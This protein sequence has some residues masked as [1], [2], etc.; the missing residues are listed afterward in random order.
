VVRFL[1]VLRYP[2]FLAACLPLAWT[3]YRE[4]QSGQEA[5][6]TAGSTGTPPALDEIEARLKPLHDRIAWT[7]QPGGAASSLPEGWK[8]WKETTERHRE[9]LA[10]A[11]DFGKRYR[12][13][14]VRNAKDEDLFGKALEAR[15]VEDRLF[16]ERRHGLQI[17]NAETIHGYLQQLDAYAKDYER[18]PA[19][20][21]VW[22][23]VIRGWLD[24]NQSLQKWDDEKSR[25][26]LQAGLKHITGDPDKPVFTR[27]QEEQVK[28]AGKELEQACEAF[29]AG[30]KLCP[31][32]EARTEFQ[33]R[34]ERRKTYWS[35]DLLGLVSRNTGESGPA[36]KVSAIAQIWK[37]LKG[38]KGAPEVKGAVLALCPLQPILDE[39][40]S[41]KG[42]AN[43]NRIHE[44]LQSSRGPWKVAEL[45]KLQQRCKD[46]QNFTYCKDPAKLKRLEDLFDRLHQV[47]Q[48]V[49]N[50]PD[51]FLD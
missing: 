11:A 30:L 15:K 51:V 28:K 25:E 49:L 8:T 47:L 41:S 18:G 36:D 10:E 16:K 48:E 45:R 9:A 12:A 7:M 32:P 26:L 19:Y 24:A 46:P 3:V 35:S 20:N 43:Y 34:L 21:S 14:G 44:E 27:D 1:V 22:Y 40:D 23:R 2:L 6:L 37:Q 4:W 5:P 39:K 31:E 33:D 50:H 13:G 29:K 17:P 42:I 38:T